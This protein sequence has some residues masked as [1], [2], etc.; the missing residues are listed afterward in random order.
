MVKRTCRA[1]HARIG[2]RLGEAHLF[3]ERGIVDLHA[4][5]ADVYL[6][7]VGG[8]AWQSPSGSAIQA[9]AMHWPR[10]GGTRQAGGRSAGLTKA[11][12]RSRL[13]LGY[14][15]GVMASRPVSPKQTKAPQNR[16]EGCF[17]AHSEL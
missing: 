5:G 7:I 9:V 1:H 11:L 8:S 10:L 2:T 13:R 15:G 3:M 14:Q 17:A 16:G 4:F 12:S 6:A